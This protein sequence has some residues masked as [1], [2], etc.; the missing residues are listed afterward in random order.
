VNIQEELLVATTTSV[1][2]L[3]KESFMYLVFEAQV[4]RGEPRRGILL[5]L[6]SH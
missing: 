5:L 4:R 3:R 6:F 2:A 1:K